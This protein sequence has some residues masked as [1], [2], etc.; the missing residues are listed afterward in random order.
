ML[1]LAKRQVIDN[2][3]HKSL[4]AIEV[5]AGVVAALINV[6]GKAAIVAGLIAHALAKGVSGG[7]SETICEMAVKLQL[8]SVIARRVSGK[9]EIGVRSSPEGV[10]FGLSQLPHAHYGSGVKVVVDDGVDGVAADVR[11][12]ENE[13]PGQRLLNRSVPRFHIRVL[14]VLI[15]HEIGAF[16]GGVGNNPV[17]WNDRVNE[18]G[19]A[20]LES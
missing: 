16:Y 14:E 2:T 17:R 11:N 18:V 13:A 15:H 12:I 10:K 7:G 5:V 19:K 4:R 3:L 6:E 1:S 20:I 8:Q 9:E